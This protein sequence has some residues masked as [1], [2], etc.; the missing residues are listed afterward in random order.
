MRNVPT[1]PAVGVVASFS[2]SPLVTV[3]VTLPSGAPSLERTV[4]A[5]LPVGG[6]EADGVEHVLSR[7]RRAPG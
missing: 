3:T 2:M 6:A 5:M 7:R 4:P 1:L